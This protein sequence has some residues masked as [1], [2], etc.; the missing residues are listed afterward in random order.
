M[1]ASTSSHRLSADVATSVASPALPDRT[2]D[3]SQ[4]SVAGYF[5]VVPTPNPATEGRWKKLTARPVPKMEEDRVRLTD[6]ANR[7]PFGYLL[8]LSAI[9]RR[10]A[11][12]RAASA[13]RQGGGKAKKVDNFPQIVGPTRMFVGSDSIKFFVKSGVPA[14][15]QLKAKM[16]LSLED[17]DKWYQMCDEIKTK[18]GFAAVSTG[19]VEGV[20]YV[21]VSEDIVFDIDGR[22]V[23]WD[24][25]RKEADQ[26]GPTQVFYGAVLL[27]TCVVKDGRAGG[28]KCFVNATAKQIVGDCG[29]VEADPRFAGC[30]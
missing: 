4:P 30:M 18:L 22:I 10:A 29:E 19:I 11:E 13:A 12:D 7:Q 15:Y 3:P 21:S 20:L 8:R 17:V 1:S 14:K 24:E 9:G 27:E 16:E 5:H 6:L 23:S 28:D 25:M 26:D 2:D